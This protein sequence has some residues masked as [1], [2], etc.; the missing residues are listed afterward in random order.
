VPL[1]LASWVP[2]ICE[3]NFDNADFNDALAAA[4]AAP[5]DA[6][7]GEALA[8]AQQV[9]NEQVPVTL[10]VQTSIPVGHVSALQGIWIDP[11]GLARFG[12]AGYA[13]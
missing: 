9:F 6:A 12:D 8:R 7:Y 10:V 1:N 3:C 11:T 2:G 4:Q 13:E 5:D